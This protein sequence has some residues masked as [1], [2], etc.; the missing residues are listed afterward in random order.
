M[1]LKAV[2]PR[3]PRHT[4]K[5]ASGRLTPRGLAST[6][7]GWRA[8]PHWCCSPAR[9]AH[10][11]GAAA[12]G[13][14]LGFAP[15]RRRP[16]AAARRRRVPALRRPSRRR[17]APARFAL[18]VAAD[19]ADAVARHLA[20]HGAA[21]APLAVVN[22]SASSPR[23][24]W[25]DAAWVTLI[26]ALPAG[27]SVAL[28]GDAAQGRA[29]PRHRRAL[30]APAARPHRPDDAAAARGAAGALRRPH[31][32]RHRLGAHRRGAGQTRGRPLRPHR[33]APPRTLRPSRHPRR[34]AAP[35]RRPLPGAVPPP[36]LLTANHS[37]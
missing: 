35:L 18:P 13:R 12:R 8:A 33:C 11:R 25:D 26:D 5:Y 31:R 4:V 1:R 29:A 17:R 6:C 3:R 22:P 27:A 37:S 7:R 20:A 19:A 9:A 34:R 10:R 30:R 28:I 36:S 16:G 32:T 24:T 14:R 21:R 15:H 23:K 2:L